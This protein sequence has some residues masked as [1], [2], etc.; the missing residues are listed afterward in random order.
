MQFL[1]KRFIGNNMTFKQIEESINMVLKYF[2]QM[3]KKARCFRCNNIL[4]RSLNHVKPYY[5]CCKCKWWCHIDEYK[6]MKKYYD[7][8]R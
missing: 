2:F 4:K 1:L 6:L 5:W 3:T 8:K 7:K